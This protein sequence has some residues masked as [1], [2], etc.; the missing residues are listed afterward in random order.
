[1]A[2]AR[3]LGPGKLTVVLKSAAG[4]KPADVN[5]LSDPYVIAQAGSGHEATSKIIKRALD[6]SWSDEALVLTGTLAEFVTSGL[7]LKVMDYDSP[8]KLKRRHDPL[9]NVHVSLDPLKDGDGPVEFTESLPTQGTIYFTVAWTPLAAHMLRHGTLHICLSHAHNLKAMDS[10]GLSDP[11][12]T[13]ALAGATRKS[14]IVKAD[15]N[16][17]WNQHFN[18]VSGILNDLMAAAP[19]RL[20]VFDWDRFGKDDD[21]GHANVSLQALESQSR[22]DLD[23]PLSEQGTVSLHVAWQAD[24]EEAPVLT[25]AGSP[26]GATAQRAAKGGGSSSSFGSQ[27]VSRRSK[28]AKRAPASEEERRTGA[29]STIQRFFRQQQRWLLWS[30]AAAPAMPSTAKGASSWWWSPFGGKAWSGFQHTL[31]SFELGRMVGTRCAGAMSSSDGPFVGASWPQLLLPPLVL[32]VFVLLALSTSGTPRQWWMPPPS[33]PPPPLFEAAT[34]AIDQVD[35]FV[36]HRV[37][38]TCNRACDKFVDGASLQST[39]YSFLCMRVEWSGD[40]A[41]QPM[42]HVGCPSGLIPCSVSHTPFLLSSFFIVPLQLLCCCVAFGWW[43]RRAAEATTMAS[44]VQ[45]GSTSPGYTR[46]GQNYY[47]ELE[48]PSRSPPFDAFDV[49]VEDPYA[50]HPDVGRQTPGASRVQNYYAQHSPG[51]HYDEGSHLESEHSESISQKTLAIDTLRREARDGEMRLNR[52]FQRLQKQVEEEQQQRKVAETEM[53]E[54][55]RLAAQ[56]QV[57]EEQRQR[58]LAEAE[59]TELRRL[60]AAARSSHMDVS[61]DNGARTTPRTPRTP[62]VT[63]DEHA[64]TPSRSATGASTGT[65]DGQLFERPRSIMGSATSP[66]SDPLRRAARCAHNFNRNGARPAVSSSPFAA[67]RG[68]GGRSPRSSS[69]GMPPNCVAQNCSASMCAG[70]GGDQ[71]PLTPRSRSPAADPPELVVT[72]TPDGWHYEH[73][74]GE[75]WEDGNEGV[76]EEAYYDDYSHTG[77]YGQGSSR[78]TPAYSQTAAHATRGRDDQ[79]TYCY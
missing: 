73:A 42:Y 62:R 26:A 54:L 41:C 33:P 57:E 65:C 31:R 3:L 29:A 44:A 40:M 63:F 24:G 68:F 79:R 7:L 39:Y 46:P 14:K 9:G 32:L 2:A 34:A 75:R 27:L 45:R 64:T 17:H 6:P 28:P 1:M 61:C 74:P 21:L 56:K 72:T 15:L 78:A 53:T 4:L 19:L 49:D 76:L 59:I 37:F 71:A 10:N 8:I 18:L 67:Q 48:T 22:I 52:E 25:W 38:D 43:R 5:G 70:I 66:R 12:V 58:K 30:A 35:R 69:C 60:A 23:V 50:H 55:R 13:I 20:H 11:Y 51:R 36:E 77:G 16:P 47:A